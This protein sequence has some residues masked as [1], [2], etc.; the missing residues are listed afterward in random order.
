MGGDVLLRIA[1]SNR[2]VEK[3]F[4][5]FGEMKKEIPA[6]W[7]RKIKKQIDRLAAADTFGDFL[8]LGLGHPEQLKGQDSGKYSIRITGN[9]RL[10]VR[11]ADDGKTVVICEEITVEGVV[12][13]HGD[14]ETWY[15]S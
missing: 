2:K 12:D 1:Y 4:S 11:P 9:V 5:D 8:S 6:E 13:Y 7:V 3:Y 14:K 10:I 15:I